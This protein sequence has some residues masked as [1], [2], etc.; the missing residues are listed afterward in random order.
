MT[1]DHIKISDTMPRRPGYPDTDIYVHVKD[2]NRWNVDAYT[3]RVESGADGGVVRVSGYARAAGGIRDF[4][5]AL[6]GIKGMSEVQ[7]GALVAAAELDYVVR[8]IEAGRGNR[9]R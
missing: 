1:L 5:V 7:I 3:E 2:T 8:E 4:E 9:P 6:P